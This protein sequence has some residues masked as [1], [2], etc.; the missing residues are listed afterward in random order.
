[1]G[2]LKNPRALTVI[3]AGAPILAGAVVSGRA[4]PEAFLRQEMTAG[5]TLRK[6]G[7]AVCAAHGTGRRPSAVSLWQ[8]SGH[9]Q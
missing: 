5:P 2:Y 3:A 9:G 6:E 4:Y 1:M 8:T 7:G